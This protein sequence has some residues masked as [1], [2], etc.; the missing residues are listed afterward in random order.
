MALGGASLAF[1][2]SWPRLLDHRRIPEPMN[3]NA[4][5]P[6]ELVKDPAHDWVGQ[7]VYTGV[8]RTRVSVAPDDR[9]ANGLTCGRGRDINESTLLQHLQDDWEWYV[10][11]W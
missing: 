6:M 10:L 11:G 3:R 5:G 2:L 7:V 1:D 8:A 9:Y 4:V